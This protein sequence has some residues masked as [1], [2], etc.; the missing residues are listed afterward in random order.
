MM[1]RRRKVGKRVNV[2][3]CQPLAV[4]AEIETDD[5]TETV[6]DGITDRRETGTEVVITVTT[7]IAVTV[8][9]IETE[10]GEELEATSDT[11]NMII[12]SGGIGESEGEVEVE[13][14]APAAPI[15]ALKSLAL[16]LEAIVPVLV[17]VKTALPHHLDPE[18]EIE[19]EIDIIK[20]VVVKRRLQTLDLGVAQPPLTD[21]I[22]LIAIVVRV[23]RLVSPLFSPLFSPRTC[24]LRLSTA[25]RMIPQLRSPLLC[26]L[27]CPAPTPLYMV[28]TSY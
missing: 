19:T 13:A 7:V 5:E 15:V 28:T 16:P 27:L 3:V 12:G 17:P 18:I 4:E 8:E 10:A 21:R 14:I 25:R 9:A 20:S 26:R 23:S 11:I 1:M 2:N 22:G 24:P 6:T